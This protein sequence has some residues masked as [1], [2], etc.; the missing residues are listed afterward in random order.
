[1]SSLIESTARNVK[2]LLP[3]VG[4]A[5]EQAQAQEQRGGELI[6]QLALGG[7]ALGGG[8]G[9]A[10][11]LANYIRSMK[12][13]QEAQDEDRLNDDTLYIPVDKS[14]AVNR[15]L[16]PGVAVTGGI[17]AAGGSYALTQAIYN[18]LQ[19]KRRQEM[20][21][22]AQNEALVAADLEVSKSAAEMTFM[23]LATAFPVAVPLLAALA[24]GGVAYAALNK[25]FPVVDRP[26]SK[27]PKRIRA[28]TSTGAV[29]KMDGP[30]KQAAFTEAD[31]EASAG[32]YLLLFVDELATAEKRASFTSELLGRVAARGLDEPSSVCREFGLPAMCEAIKGAHVPSGMAKVAAAAVVARDPFM[33]PVA[34]HLAAAEFIDRLP[35]ISRICAAMPAEQLDKAAGLGVLLHEAWFRPTLIEKSASALSPELLGNLMIALQRQGNQPSGAPMGDVGEEDDAALTTDLSGSMAEDAEGDQD[36]NADANEE[37]QGKDDVIDAFI[38]DPTGGL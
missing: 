26:K 31:C 12:Q 21:D 9:L 8:T 18:Y 3:G 23:D 34:Q 4:A 5:N 7:A 24:S 11:I 15:W 33:G 27:Y 2:N 28:V 14:A 30:V 1:M 29:E 36:S 13:E 22:D 35:E 25:T 37:S 20:L 16:A 17:L 19:R 6:K 10:V 32:E 38:E